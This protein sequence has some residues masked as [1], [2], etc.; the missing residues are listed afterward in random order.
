LEKALVVSQEQVKQA[1][2]QQVSYCVDMTE[3]ENC[4]YCAQLFAGPNASSAR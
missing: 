2:A 1:Q 3:L 4:E